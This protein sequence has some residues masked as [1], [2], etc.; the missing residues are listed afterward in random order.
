[1]IVVV[2]VAIKTQTGRT[3]KYKRPLIFKVGDDGVDWCEQYACIGTGADAADSLLSYRGHDETTLGYR[4]TYH[5]YEAMKF[6]AEVA[7]DV[8]AGTI[9]IVYDNGS[10]IVAENLKGA[11]V[12]ALRKKFAK[13]LGPRTVGKLPLLRERDVSQF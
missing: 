8:G 6:G 11:Y 4:A 13:L 12:K 9:A 10:R 1:L 5:V 3:R 2:F 7:P